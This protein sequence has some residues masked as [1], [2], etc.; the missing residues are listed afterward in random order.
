[1]QIADEPA[2]PGSA[3]PGPQ[4]ERPTL[5]EM[6]A[7][8]L[9]VG[10]GIVGLAAAAECLRRNPRWRLLVLEKENRV[11]AHQSSHNSG[12]IHSGLYYRPGS[13]KARTC[14]A[15]AAAMTAF[16]R[17][18]GLP[19]RVCGKLVV[20][21]TEKEVPALRE[22]EQRG[23]ANGVPN[24]QFLSAALIRA[25]EPHCGG[26]AALHIPGTAITDYGAVTGKLAEIVAQHG[27][28]IHTGTRV[29]AIQE[30]SAQIVVET[31]RGTFAA[32]QLV[33]CAGLHSDQLCRL[34]A[35]RPPAA[36]PG[37]NLTEASIIPFRGEYYELAPEKRQLVNRLIY[38]V[39]DP[40]FPFLGVHF[41]P[42][43]SGG[44]EVGPNAVLAWRREGYKRGDFDLADVMTMLRFPG[45]RRMVQRYW[46]SGL[47]EY[48]RSFDKSAFVRDAQKL[49]PE[50]RK[51][52]LAPGGSGVR[53][54]AVDRAGNLIDDF[55]LVR[56]GNIIHVL[57]VPSP[58][59]TASLAIARVIADLTAGK[60]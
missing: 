21:T 26:V 55:C 38:P 36:L 59:A 34:S 18:H 51:E 8:I 16:C 11:G 41:T 7:D 60:E 40:R 1:M 46:R 39:P 47:A 58:A 31:S 53:A 35:A 33:N 29:T 52:D 25:M 19:L 6:R 42:R 23:I 50:L 56:A 10:G 27:G 48:Y 32:R 44:I 2:S 12:V 45:F 3:I 22:L 17:Q 24:I 57:N 13:I 30:S 37:S 15:G 54:Q 9:F 28:E 5:M 43:V 14:V 49:L 20:A 4:E